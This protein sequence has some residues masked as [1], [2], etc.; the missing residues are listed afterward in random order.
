VIQPQPAASAP[1]P[2]ASSAKAV[3]APL[4]P[5]TGPLGTAHPVVLEKAAADGRWAA[6]CQAREDTDGDGKVAVTLGPRGELGGDD[7]RSY[8]VGAGGAG[9]PI[10]GFV[11]SDAADRFVALIRERRLIVI[12]TFEGKTIDLSARGADVRSDAANYLP[13]RAVAFDDSGS[14]LLYLRRESDRTRVITLDLV[15]GEEQ[16]IDPGP[17]V[18]WRAE[19]SSGLVVLKVVASDTNG[20]GR[21]DFPVPEAD[22]AGWR[23]RG[24]IPRFDAWQPRD[25]I[26]VRVVTPGAQ[27][28]QPVAGF[29]AGFGSDLVVREPSGRLVLLRRAAPDGPLATVAELAAARCGARILGGDVT[30]RLLVLAC[31]SVPGR[32][33]VVLVG[34]GYMSELKVTVEPRAND[35][36]P[37]R[38]ERLFA[39]YPGA[40]GLLLDF[41]TRTTTLL[42]AGETVISSFETGVLVRRGAS[43][44]IRDVKS[45]T[46]TQ[47]P[48]QLAENG[49]VLHQPPIT[50][51]SPAVIDLSK[52]ALV[53]ALPRGVRPLALA[54]DGRVLLPAR[55]ADANALALGPLTWTT[56]S[57]PEIAAQAR[58]Q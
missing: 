8:F 31:T 10:D 51:V 35:S 14:R 27:S 29:V 28:A 37:H 43:L 16:A 46:Q 4:P 1:P 26:E 19:L 22:G 38:A 2:A 11:G 48:V 5:P 56:P 34:E 45:G 12:D 50:F 44:S 55:S 40:Q 15:S 6:L 13:H 53:G 57:S 39:L 54:R 41:E 24:P 52:S 23:C 32:S 49:D 7:M 42:E 17:G 47:L 9:E 18:V 30:R 20:N 21:L 25:A 58:G 36:L 33:P 3:A